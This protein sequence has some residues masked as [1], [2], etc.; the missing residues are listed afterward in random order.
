MKESIWASK[1]VSVKFNPTYLRL[2]AF[3]FN[4]STTIVSILETYLN[5][6]E[7]LELEWN[8]SSSMEISDGFIIEKLTSSSH[9]D[10]ICPRLKA[11]TI[12]H[13]ETTDADLCKGL[14]EKL[15]NAREDSGILRFEAYVKSEAEAGSFEF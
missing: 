3:Y 10:V 4:F 1:D 9:G 15:V 5:S 6:L 2:Q 8:N 13:H 7:E 14:M 12:V 11:M